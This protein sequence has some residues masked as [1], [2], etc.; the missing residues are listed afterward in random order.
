MQENDGLPLNNN[1][2]AGV[3]SLKL[4]DNLDGVAGTVLVK[5]LSNQVFQLILGLGVVDANLALPYQLLHEKY[6][7]GMCFA[8]GL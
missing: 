4:I 2:L 8:R 1:E 6:L 3:S 5:V 7:S